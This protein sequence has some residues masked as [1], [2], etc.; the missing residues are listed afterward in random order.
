MGFVSYKINQDNATIGLIAVCP[1][2]QGK[3]IGSKLLK[4]V[5]QQLVAINIK[6]LFIPTQQANETACS[7]YK[8]H[9]YQI[10]EKVQIKHY[11]KDDTI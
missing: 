2:N 5:E 4:Y 3:K 6:K 10:H 7:F 8:K 9:G 11:W 1:N